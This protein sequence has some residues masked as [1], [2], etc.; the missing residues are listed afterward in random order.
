MIQ[1]LINIVNYL[2]TSVAAQGINRRRAKTD[3]LWGQYL[4][5]MSA[6][7]QRQPVVD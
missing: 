2:A 6:M 1:R 7:I 5:N 3:P 4:W